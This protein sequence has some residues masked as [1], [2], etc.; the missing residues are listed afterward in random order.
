MKFLFPF[1]FMTAIIQ[2]TFFPA[3]IVLT[4]IIAKSYAHSDQ[5]DY[6]LA[7][8]GGL[9]IG[10][11]QSSNCGLQT[12]ILTAAVFLTHLYRQ[13]PFSANLVFFIPFTF[14]I[15]FLLNLMQTIIQIGT[16]DW[17]VIIFESVLCILIFSLIRALGLIGKESHALKLKL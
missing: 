6:Y 9:S 11:F 5:K 15:V 2:S 12:L 16:I 3:N 17:S 14:I 8:L 7:L 13:T 4:I 1:I 10:L